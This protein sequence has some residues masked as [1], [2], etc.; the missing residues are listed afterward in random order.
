[1]TLNVFD[2]FEWIQIK[3][4]NVARSSTDCEQSRD[5]VDRQTVNA[6]FEIYLS[7][8]I[9][10]EVLDVYHLIL[11]TTNHVFS[12][13]RELCSVNPILVRL[14]LEFLKIVLIIQYLALE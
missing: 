8:L 5:G 12:A 10:E 3:Q 7:C 1:M 11:T 2:F 4:G 6:I 9:F 13:P 14:Q